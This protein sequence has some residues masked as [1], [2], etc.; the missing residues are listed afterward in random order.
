MSNEHTNNNHRPVL[1]QQALAYLDIK[2]N[3]AYID[4]TFGRGGH[5]Q[6]ILR[7][8]DDRGQLIVFDWDPQ[9]QKAAEAIEDPRFQ[10]YPH[11]FTEIADTI[12]H[13]QLT[14]SIDGLLMDLG[15]SSPQLDNPERGFSFKGGGPLDMRMD[16]RRGRPASEWLNHIDQKT[17]TEILK[18]YGEEPFAGRIARHIVEKRPIET[19]DKLAGIITQAV[20]KK[21]RGIHPATRTFQA[22]RIYTNQEF[23]QLESLLH[24]APKLLTK[25]GRLVVISFHSLEDRIV[26][27]ILRQQSR[28]EG[29][30]SVL[31]KKPVKAGQAADL[32]NRRARSACLRA[33]ER[34]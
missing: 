21:P 20:P 32:E 1:L 22:L 7:A 4:A 16:P 10:F 28:D 11:A 33:A 8:L 23:D 12:D 19:T 31:T 5:S 2:P 17:L 6:A 15:V 34:C 27:H 29:V 18:S 3:G 25:G 13:L 26:K 24:T 9:A 30:M 14:G